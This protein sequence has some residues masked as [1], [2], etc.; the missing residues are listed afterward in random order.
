MAEFKEYFTV[1]AAR[2]HEISQKALVP[3][4]QVPFRD[5]ENIPAPF[6]VESYSL[7]AIDSETRIIKNKTF[8]PAFSQE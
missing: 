3:A 7:F 6:I 8:Y 5:N 2:E 4:K 1:S